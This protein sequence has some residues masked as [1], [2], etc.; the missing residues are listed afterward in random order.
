MTWVPFHDLT[1]SRK[2]VTLKSCPPSKHCDMHSSAER[3]IHTHKQIKIEKR[4][5]KTWSPFCL[6]PSC[7]RNNGSY[8][9]HRSHRDTCPSCFLSSHMPYSTCFPQPSSHVQI[10]EWKQFSHLQ[11]TKPTLPRVSQGELEQSSPYQWQSV[12]NFKLDFDWP[13][14]V[15]CTMFMCV[16]KLTP[17]CTCECWKTSWRSWLSCHYFRLAK[18]L[19]Y[20]LSHPAGPPVNAFPS[21]TSHVSTIPEE[22]VLLADIGSSVW[23][24][25]Q[26]WST[27]SIADTCHGW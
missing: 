1:G 27:A 5:G 21:R 26:Y 9:W 12:F 17:Q 6:A 18:K 20:S 2:K 19:R 15:Y 14:C 11:I 25:G 23:T 24:L 10:A 8:M 16:G 22:N 4:K 3:E 7:L 13:I